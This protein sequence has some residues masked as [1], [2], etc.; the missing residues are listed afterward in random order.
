MAAK[1]KPAKRVARAKDTKPAKGTKRKPLAIE[2]QLN[3]LFK[4][5]P[6]SNEFLR[7]RRAKALETKP[8]PPP[9]PV[10]PKVEITVRTIYHD[11]Q[12]VPALCF[13]TPEDPHVPAII[14]D[15]VL[16]V[17]H[18][19]ITAK[20]CDKATPVEHGPLKIPYPVERFTAHMKRLA[21]S[22]PVTREARALLLPLVPDMPSGYTPPERIE[23]QAATDPGSTDAPPARTL[24]KP[25]SV[26]SGPSR[27]CGKELIR[28]LADASKL[29]PE[30]VR[31]KLR[32]SGMRAPYT[33][34]AACR[35]ALGLKEKGK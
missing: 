21:A 31:A 27:T 26:R 24:S 8:A 25:A 33:D 2:R 19:S 5:E 7:K 9:E 14:G 11:G 34:E 15:S 1:K 6:K 16:G 12:H 18:L 28:A 3:E 29:P 10:K 32:S 4:P 13:R 17:R 22:A 30:K 23:P 35:K 20:Q